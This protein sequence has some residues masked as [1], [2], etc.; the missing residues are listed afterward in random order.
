[1]NKAQFLDFYYDNQAPLIICW[2]DELR[3]LANDTISIVTRN[4]PLA[5]A[6]DFYVF[7]Y[8][9]NGTY[10]DRP[11]EEKLDDEVTSLI[12]AGEAVTDISRW[13]LELPGEELSLDRLWPIPIA[14]DMGSGKTLILDGN[15]TLA[16][17]AADMRDKPLT[18]L[19]FVEVSG[20]DLARIVPDFKVLNRQTVLL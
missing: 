16:N 3:F 7:R 18:M 2:F 1:M 4:I 8:S 13:D 20:H 19:P 6:L 17:L 15:H 14:T 12:T 5:E 9:V 11:I 10:D